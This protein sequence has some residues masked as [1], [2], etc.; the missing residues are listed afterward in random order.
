MTCVTPRAAAA[1]A[2]CSD[3]TRGL[4]ELAGGSSSSVAT[5]GEASRPVADVTIRDAPSQQAQA[6]C[7]DD[8]PVVFATGFELREVVV[9]GG[10]DHGI[11]RCCAFAQT[12]E[13]VDR[14]AMGFG[15]CRSRAKRR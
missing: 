10:M 9:E 4:G 8:E 1:A 14:A 6:E 15:T 13:I 11:S 12:F 7:S 3:A 5:R 2:A